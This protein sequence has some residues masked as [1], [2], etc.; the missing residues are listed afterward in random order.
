ME[1]VL[2]SLFPEA[3]IQ[4]V[5]SDTMRHRSEY[6]RIVSDFEARKIDVLVGTQMIAKGLDFPFVSFVGVLH[7]DPA[8]LA[9]DFRA[10]ERLFQLI[11]QVAGRAG[12]ADIPGR[13]I[14]Q[15]TTPDIP[16]LR[17]AL[18][19][20]YE[21]FA[22]GE[23]A[24]RRKVGLPPFRR[25][26][27][28]VLADRRDER[29]LRGA[30]TLATG[31][32]TTIEAGPYELADVYGPNPCVL[33]RLRGRYRYDLTIRTADA[34]TLR[35]LLRTMRESGLLRAKVDSMMIDVDPVSML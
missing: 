29:A 3:A 18:T 23:L 27:R 11:T 16:A 31:I 22:S 9:S 10:S 33:K 30:E 7:A 1:D 14:V 26:A 12:R 28:I 2:T 6:Q 32:R 19:H 21:S 8:G 24:L 15:T 20:D 5:D 25:L 35:R 34:S 17:H 4:R 13:V